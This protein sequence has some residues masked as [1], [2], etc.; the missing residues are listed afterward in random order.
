MRLCSDIRIKASHIF[1][2]SQ[3]THCTP[4][5]EANATHT[6]LK[7]PP[8]PK[9]GP[10]SNTKEKLLRKEREKRR[11]PIPSTLCVRQGKTKH[12]PEKLRCNEFE[13]EE[14]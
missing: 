2:K 12:Q 7:T 5:A 13:K 8:A 14:K 10:R 4:G 11:G 1:F 9:E 6:H 3:Q